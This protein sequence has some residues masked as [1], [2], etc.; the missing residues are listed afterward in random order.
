MAPLQ[1]VVRQ[2]S[3]SFSHLFSKEIKKQMPDAKPIQILMHTMTLASEAEIKIKKYKRINDDEATVMQTNA[4]PPNEY[5]VIA[6]QKKL[7]QSIKM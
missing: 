7:R 2:Q 5:V 6:I 4:K 1:L 3:C